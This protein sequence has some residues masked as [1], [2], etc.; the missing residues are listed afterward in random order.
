MSEVR[1]KATNMCMA[2]AMPFNQ[3]WEYWDTVPVSEMLDQMFFLPVRNMLRAGDQVCLTRFDDTRETLLEVAT[4]RVVRKVDDP[5]AKR[6]EMLLIGDVHRPVKAETVRAGHHE[7]TDDELKD[8]IADRTGSKPRGNPS[9]ET[10]VRL[11]IEAT[12]VEPVPA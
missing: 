5:D 11:A 1:A 8:L 3:H 12:Q 6:V 10:L 7:L 2:D 4:V 9:H